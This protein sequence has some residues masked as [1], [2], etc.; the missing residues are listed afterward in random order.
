MKTNGNVVDDMWRKARDSRWLLFLLDRGGLGTPELYRS[1][2]HRCAERALPV[3]GNGLLPSW[4]RVLDAVR[5]CVEGNITEGELHQTGKK[6]GG[7]AMAAGSIG[8]RIG[9]P[10]AALLLAIYHA[11]DPDA[12]GAAL[13]ASLY[14]AEAFRLQAL[15]KEPDAGEQ[16]GDRARKLER[17]EQARALRELAGRPFADGAAVDRFEELPL[18]DYLRRGYLPDPHFQLDGLALFAPVTHRPWAF[19]RST[20]HGLRRVETVRPDRS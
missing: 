17:K 14:G 9:D 13:F 7:A 19:V 5:D 12:L 2:A 8:L 4:Q 1:F 11:C 6:L 18:E 10:G 16:A 15:R 3:R 20:S